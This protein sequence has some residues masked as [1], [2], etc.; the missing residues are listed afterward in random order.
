ML[1]LFIVLLG[2]VT[3][4]SNCQTTFPLIFPRVFGIFTPNFST[5]VTKN[6]TKLLV[7]KSGLEKKIGG[8]VVDHV[9]HL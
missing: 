5:K 4:F 1:M 7:P 9:R 2:V 6:M 8:D 3:K